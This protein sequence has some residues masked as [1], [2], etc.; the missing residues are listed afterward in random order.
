MCS[1]RPSTTDHG[2]TDAGPAAVTRARIVDAA[3]RLIA[4]DGVAGTSLRAIAE[5]ADVSAPLVIHHFGSKAGL[6]KA[7]DARVVDQLNEALGSFTESGPGETSVQAMMALVA[8][9]PALAYVARA[10]SEGGEAGSR[11]F[12]DSFALTLVVQSEM[13]A[14]GVA[15]PTD[16]PEMLALLLGAMDLG[17]LLMRPHVERVLGADLF[18]EAVVERWV[19]AEIDLLTEGLLRPG[20]R[21]GD[22]T[23]ARP[24]PERPETGPDAEEAG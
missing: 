19:R 17:L 20:G 11:L 9:T 1:A 18:D 2:P 7:C 22:A 12:D 6:V 15:R 23:S 14:A 10:L 24:G 21:S 8:H 16:D 5:A 13:T 3:C 4:A